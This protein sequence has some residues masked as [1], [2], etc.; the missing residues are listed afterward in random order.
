MSGGMNTILK[1]EGVPRRIEYIPQ[2]LDP[3]NLWMRSVENA[4]EKET[5]EIWEWKA[6]RKVYEGEKKKVNGQE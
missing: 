3:C 2:F 4:M 6:P 1:S 5:M